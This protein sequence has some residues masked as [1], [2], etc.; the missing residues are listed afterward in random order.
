MGHFD[1]L[2]EAGFRCFRGPENKWFETVPGE[3]LRAGLRLIDGRLATTPCVQHVQQTD[4][5]LWM[6][7]SSQFYAPFMS[8][9]RHVSLEARVMKAVKGLRRAAETGGVFHLWTHPF[10]L[11]IRTDELL[12]GLQRILYEAG[13]LR[14]AGRLDIL[15]MG[16][17]AER[18]D[19]TEQN[20]PRVVQAS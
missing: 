17:I 18:M 13:R 2:A 5:R 14:D 20:S 1:L 10:N 9:G 3:R 19:Q 7:P 6:I 4:D 12:T 15:P 11:G 8:V 16:G